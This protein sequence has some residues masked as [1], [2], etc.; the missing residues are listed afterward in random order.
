MLARLPKMYLSQWLTS[1][2]AI[3]YAVVSCDCRRVFIE[4]TI[5]VLSYLLSL[6]PPHPPNNHHGNHNM[7]GCYSAWPWILEQFLCAIQPRQPCSNSKPDTPGCSLRASQ[8]YV[9]NSKTKVNFLMLTIQVKL[10]KILFSS[11]VNFLLWSKAT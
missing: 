10:V 1:H 3:Q 9:N 4:I 5:L 7:L 11:V 6:P 8:R 2:I